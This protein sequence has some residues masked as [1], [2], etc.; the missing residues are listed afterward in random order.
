[1]ATGSGSLRAA[2]RSSTP[3][4]SAPPICPSRSIMATRSEGCARGSRA[5]AR[6]R[7]RAA[8][9]P[10]RAARRTSVGLGA[11]R[12]QSR[13][14]GA[15]SGAGDCSKETPANPSSIPRQTES[16]ASASGAESSSRPQPSR[17]SG[18]ALEASRLANRSSR[19]RRTRSERQASGDASSR[20][21]SSRFAGMCRSSPHQTSRGMCGSDASSLRSRSGFRISRAV[22]SGR[23]RAV[24]A[25]WLR[26]ATPG[27][28]A[29]SAASSAAIPGETRRASPRNRTVQVRT[30]ALAW[31][32]NP[33][34]VAS[35]K[36]PVV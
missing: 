3:R 34:A 15:P 10:R 16:A 11:R 9:L 8:A 26:T 7:P 19:W 20:T 2:S 29:A 36:P 27:S 18:A 6:A 24:A 12:D 35:S 13:A 25:S 30:G 22:V 33:A 31:R 32:S 21:S 1:M 17:S 5:S 14:R 4:L 28:R 23:R